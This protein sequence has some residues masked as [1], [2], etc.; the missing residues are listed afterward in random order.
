MTH[1]A[2]VTERVFQLPHPETPICVFTVNSS[3]YKLSETHSLGEVSVSEFSSSPIF[4]STVLQCKFLW[5]RSNMASATESQGP[6]FH[7]QPCLSGRSL[8]PTALM[9]CRFLQ[10]R[11]CMVRDQFESGWEEGQLGTVKAPVV[12]LTWEQVFILRTSIISWKRMNNSEG[13]VIF[14]THR[15]WTKGSAR[16][17]YCKSSLMRMSK[18]VLLMIE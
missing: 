6:P 15:L 11:P 5:W 17:Y 10:L 3:H 18:N 12:K 2:P 1:L 9:A 8:L 16:L 13:R 4:S 7:T 14:K